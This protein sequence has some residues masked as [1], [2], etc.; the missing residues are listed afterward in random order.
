MDCW[1]IDIVEGGR[2]GLVVAPLLVLARLNP[3]DALAGATSSGLAIENAGIQAPLNG[4][5]VWIGVYS[6]SVWGLFRHHSCPKRG[7]HKSSKVIYTL[8]FPCDS[9]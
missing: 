1:I 6:S 9:C 7:V 8:Q 2:G 4:S 5:L 3:S